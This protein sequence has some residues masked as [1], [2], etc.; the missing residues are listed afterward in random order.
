MLLI[1]VFS[2]LQVFSS[3]LTSFC[4]DFIVLE[5]KIQRNS[6]DKHENIALNY[7]HRVISKYILERKETDVLKDLVVGHEGSKHPATTIIAQEKVNRAR[8]FPPCS[9]YPD[10]HLLS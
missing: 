7:P 9:T 10:L 8:L 6:E 2:A 5:L 4:S 3:S 1:T